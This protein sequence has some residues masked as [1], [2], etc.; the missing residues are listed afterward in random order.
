MD[1]LNPLLMERAA[2]V[3]QMR[4]LVAAAESRGSVTVADKREI[5]ALS[6]EIQDLDARVEACRMRDIVPPFH[7][8]GDD[9]HASALTRSG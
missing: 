8:R 3:E 1:N 5:D 7:G 6:D 9:T 2:K 4:G